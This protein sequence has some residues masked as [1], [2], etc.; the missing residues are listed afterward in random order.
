[1]DFCVW[2]IGLEF[3][4]DE[5]IESENMYESLERME[6]VSP[7]FLF[8][9]DIL[10]AAIDYWD[11]VS[12]ML[13]FQQSTNVEEYPPKQEVLAAKPKLENVKEE[14]EETWQ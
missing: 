11:F 3:L 7:G 10:M 1:M 4:G 2:L 5:K 8:C 6:Q 12:F 14:K 9:L 13:S